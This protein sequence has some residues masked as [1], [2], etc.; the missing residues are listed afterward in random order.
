MT[1]EKCLEVLLLYEEYLN[2]IGFTDGTTTHLKEML[3][4]MKVFLGEGRRD[5][6]FRW[7]GFVQGSLWTLGEFTL[8]ELCNHNKPDQGE[9]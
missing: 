1:N 7:L 9:K 3:P 2:N 5:K 4:K 8:E 6:F